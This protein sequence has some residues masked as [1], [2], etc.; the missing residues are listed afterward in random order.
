MGRRI[1]VAGR[2]RE[3][4]LQLVSGAFSQGSE[5]W[6]LVEPRTS[7]ELASD[8]ADLE[9]PQQIVWNS[10][11][12]FSARGA[13]T[14]LRSDEKSLDEAVVVFSP[15]RDVTAFHELSAAKI[16][17]TVDYHLKGSLFLLKE[18]LTLFEAQ[19]GG[20]LTLVSYDQGEDY[21]SPLDALVRSALL[22]IA[23]SLFAGYDGSRILIR[24]YRSS[25]TEPAAFA[26]YALAAHREKPQKSAGKWHR[27][28]GKS[29][30][31]SLG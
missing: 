25:G 29:G 3:L 10:R 4:T 9:G 26:E 7:S 23:D 5:V 30:L 22:G 28:T 15:L 1:L 18:L 24:G 2:H 20:T 17:E 16:E 12:P 19:N 31:F 8:L 27:Y 21:L 14:R 13:L 11:S 6:A